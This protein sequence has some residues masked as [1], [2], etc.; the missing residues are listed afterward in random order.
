MVSKSGLEPNE[1]LLDVDVV[2]PVTLGFGLGITAFG[3][4]TL[5]LTLVVVS[6]VTRDFPE[7]R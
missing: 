2:D 1:T 5:S 3:S 4:P 7:G 6:L